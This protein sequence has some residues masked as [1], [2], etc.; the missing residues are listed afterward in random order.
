MGVLMGVL[1]GLCSYNGLLYAAWKGESEDDRLF[2]SEFNE[3]YWTEQ[4]LVGGN[5][6]AGPAVVNFR[7]TMVLGWKGEHSDERVFYLKVDNGLWSEQNQVPVIASTT[8]PSLAEFNNLLFAAWKGAGADQGI[9]WATYDGSNWSPQAL[10]PNVAT[11]VGP[12][13]C[14]YDG[15]LYAAWKGWKNDQAL[16]FASFDGKNWSQQQEIPGVASAFGPSLAVYNGRLYA[17]WRGVTGD[18]SLWYS[19]FDGRNWTPQQVIPNVASSIGPALSEYAGYLYAMWKGAGNDQGLY[20]SHFDGANWLPQDQIPGNTGPDS[21]Q[22]IGLRMQYQQTNQWCWIAVAVSVARY[23]G[24]GN[25]NTYQC[26]AMTTIG[27]TINNWSADTFCCPTGAMEQANPGLLAKLLDPYSRNSEYAL[28]NVGI[29]K[30]CIKSGGVGDA[31]NLNNNNAGLRQTMR[32]D[33]I[34]TEIDAGRP[35]VATIQWLSGVEHY[36][37]IAGVLNDQLL[38]CDPIN[39][40]TVISYDTFPAQYQGGATLVS[41]HLT[42]AA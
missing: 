38:V 41:F 34:T 1:Q 18:E 26:E 4:Q 9:W 8:G 10:I 14:T 20:Y 37:A 36:V 3:R 42:K 23:Y 28:E 21:P 22:N 39:G 16:W 32:L 6:S 31:L 25:A 5:S 12:A 29:P 24:Y 33:E 2:F 27:Q 40:E 30:V 35:V 11:S 19:S 15:W 17:A 13:L 7:G